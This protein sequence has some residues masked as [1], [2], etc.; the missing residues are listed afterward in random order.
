METTVENLV[1]NLFSSIVRLWDSSRMFSKLTFQAVRPNPPIT[2]GLCAYIWYWAVK[3]HL[4]KTFVQTKF[5]YVV[6][7][8]VYLLQ[9]RYY[10]PLSFSYCCNFWKN[11]NWFDS[12]T[13]MLKH[14]QA[15]MSTLE[16]YKNWKVFCGLKEYF[17]KYFPK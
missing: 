12:N 5:Q 14:R 2:F 6:N 4:D 3:H 1:C 15:K 13:E 10:H 17:H 9:Q 8:F 11:K 16:F 7:L